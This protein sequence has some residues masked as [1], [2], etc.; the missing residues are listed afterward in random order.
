[1]NYSV[2][3][4]TRVL[5]F[6]AV[7]GLV[8]VAFT[9]EPRGG[10]AQ[11]RDAKG[12]ANESYQTCARACNEC[13]QVCLSCADHCAH[14]AAEGKKDHLRTLRMCHDCAAHCAAAA[15][16][17]A[18]QGPLSELICTACAEACKQCG[19]E[20]E[21]FKDDPMMKKCADECRKCEKAC[22]DMI[23]HMSEQKN[24]GGASR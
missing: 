24:R 14:M 15:R 7:L 4:I 2:N 17:T 22:V 12:G 16:I 13:E 3:H 9:Q 8:G 1:M 6:T 20:C 10:Q 11:P 19:N 18:S 5:A 21:K 23:K